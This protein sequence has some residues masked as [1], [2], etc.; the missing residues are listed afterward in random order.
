M[1]VLIV[2]QLNNDIMT[3]FSNNTNRMIKLFNKCNFP[4]LNLTRMIVEW[5]IYS[6]IVVFEMIVNRC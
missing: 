5:F 6:F 1:F 4:D 3:F 2:S